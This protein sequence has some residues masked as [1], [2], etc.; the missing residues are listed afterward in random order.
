MD[1][2][3]YSPNLEEPP[4]NTATLDEVQLAEGAGGSRIYAFGP[5]GHLDSLDAG[6]NLLAFTFDAAGQ[7]A[8]IDRTA[9]E[10]VDFRYDGRGYLAEV[11]ATTAAFHP[12]PAGTADIIFN[13]DFEGGDI[14]YWELA[15][16]WGGPGCPQPPVQNLLAAVY[17]SSGLLHALLPE[18]EASDLKLVFYLAGRPVATLSS[19]TDP[20]VTFITT[21]HLG[22]PILALDINGNSQWLGGFEPFGHDWQTGASSA[23]VNGVFL[24][25]PGQWRDPIW[26]NASLGTELLYNVHRWYEPQTGRYA[27]PDP[28]G[29][30]ASL[31]DYVYVDSRPT[32]FHDPLG[33]IAVDGDSCKSYCCD[34]GKAAQQYN[35]FFSPGWRQRHPKCWKALA[36]KS[37]KWTPKDNSVLSPLSCMVTGH[38]D[39]TVSCNPKA[40]PPYECG[41]TI[42]GST[43]FGPEACD[44]AQCGS[45]FNTLFHEQL[46]RCGAPPE[47]GGLVTIAGDIAYDCVGK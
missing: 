19:A 29:V 44:S 42:E 40:K 37:G 23:T 16:G 35:D 38:R 20:L 45:P 11:S 25:L 5:A 32:Y 17:D 1:L 3:V 33:L 28:L 31:N 12:R 4:G 47:S 6:A 27:S 34:L 14:C 46:H 8:S 10:F 41:G 21:D 26:E 30:A 9:E 36:S 43:F 2:Y 15:V 24:R 13:D 39:V 7:L 18:G 22:A